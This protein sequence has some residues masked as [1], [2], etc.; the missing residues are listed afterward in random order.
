MEEAW[1]SGKETQY[2]ILEFIPE[3]RIGQSEQGRNF[4]FVLPRNLILCAGNEEAYC[5][6][7]E[8]RHPLPLTKVPNLGITRSERNSTLCGNIV[9]E[10]Q[11]C[12]GILC[13]DFEEQ[14]IA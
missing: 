10:I 8:F 3:G 5:M 11:H 2:S 12:V 7:I 13:R 4:R 9:K 1:Y 14:F 6:P